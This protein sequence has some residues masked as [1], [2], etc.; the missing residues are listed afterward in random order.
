MLVVQKGGSSKTADQVG[1][2]EVN[3]KVENRRD[4]QMLTTSKMVSSL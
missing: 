2:A 1:L 4:L 3:D